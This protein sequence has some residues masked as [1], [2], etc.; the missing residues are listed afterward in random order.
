VVAR[1]PA[2]HAPPCRRRPGVEPAQLAVGRGLWHR[3]GAVLPRVQSDH[4]EPE[5]RPGRRLHPPL[6]RGAARPD[7]RRGAPAVE[8]PGRSARRVPGADRDPAQDRMPRSSARR[9]RST[10]NWPPRWA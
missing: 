6:R 1:G 4:P 9:C 3:R 7:R 8:P 2:L 5:V 10:P